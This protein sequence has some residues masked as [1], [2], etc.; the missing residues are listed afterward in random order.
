MFRM[1]DVQLRHAETRRGGVGSGV[2]VGFFSL[3]PLPLFFF[4]FLFMKL[5]RRKL[6][7]LSV[8][9]TMQKC[10]DYL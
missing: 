8:W 5:C 4:L 9:A 2:F 7:D 1:Y 6:Q 3:P 10:K